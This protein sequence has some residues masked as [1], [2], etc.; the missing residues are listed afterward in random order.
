MNAG[1]GRALVEDAAAR[2]KDQGAE[3]LEVTA[4]P[5]QGF[6]K[7]SASTES[8]RRD[9]LRPDGAY[10]RYGCRALTGRTRV[11]PRGRR[12]ARGAS[13]RGCGARP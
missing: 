2:A 3:A 12:L 7:G 13:R 9:P 11:S 1:V 6:Y 5:A 4:G 10:R 8:A